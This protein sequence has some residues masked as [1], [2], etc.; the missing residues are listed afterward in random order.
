MTETDARTRWADAPNAEAIEAWDGAALRP[1]PPVPAILI[2]AAWRRTASAR[3]SCSRRNRP[4]ASWTSAAGSAID[5]AARRARRARRE[6]VGVD[7]AAAFI[8]R[9]PRG[10]SREADRQR[11]LPRGRRPV[12]AVASPSTSPSR[13]SARCSSRARSPRCA[14]CARR[15]PPADASRWRSGGGARTTTG[16]T[17]PRRSSRA[18]QPARGVRRA[19]VRARPVLDGRRRHDER[20]HAVRRLRGRCTAALRHA[21]PDR[22]RPGRGDRHRH[23]PRARRRDPA[24]APATAP[25]TSAGPSRPPCTTGSTTSWAPTARCARGPRAGS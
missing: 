12:R 25:P 15:S 22:Q 19:D 1:L 17:A 8:E 11:P 2:A 6:A 9:R 23:G 14:T 3:S 13:G 24:P 5:A 10:G 7:A 21:D 18:R 20:R 4:S 16:S